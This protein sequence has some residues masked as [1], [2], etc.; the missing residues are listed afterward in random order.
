MPRTSR[1][2][3]VLA[4]AVR[5][6]IAALVRPVAPCAT[7]ATWPV[8]VGDNLICYVTDEATVLGARHPDLTSA[9]PEPDLER[10]LNRLDLRTGEVR[11][12][13]RFPDNFVCSVLLA[14]GR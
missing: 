3:W 13:L 2:L 10:R 9:V 5:G 4:L 14:G 1:G 7:R 6:I 12:L 8:S 11:T